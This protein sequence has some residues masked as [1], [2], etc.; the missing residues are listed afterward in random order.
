MYCVELC[1]VKPTGQCLF[2]CFLPVNDDDA[3]GVSGEPD[4][5]ADRQCYQ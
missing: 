2:L 3:A 1:S 5:T 4:Q